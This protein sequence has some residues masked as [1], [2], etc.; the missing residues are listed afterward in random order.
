MKS[1]GN[2]G[3][4]Q[5]KFFEEKRKN[6]SASVHF[7]YLYTHTS[8][9]CLKGYVS[10]LLAALLA[11]TLASQLTLMF[12]DVLKT[13]SLFHFLVQLF[14]PPT[15]PLHAYSVHRHISRQ[16]NLL[17][18]KI[19]SSQGAAWLSTRRAKHRAQCTNLPCGFSM[20]LSKRYIFSPLARLFHWTNQH[21]ASETSGAR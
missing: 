5:A 19:Q 4:A 2:R 10:V 11:P 13:F 1:G 12:A 18:Y 17:S 16:S 3:R 21:R 14:L 7:S 8:R 6:I 9:Q 20:R 15:V